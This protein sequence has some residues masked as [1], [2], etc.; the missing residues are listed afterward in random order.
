VTRVPLF[1]FDGWR[2]DWNPRVG[3]TFSRGL[4]RIRV[5]SNG[6]WRPGM[7]NVVHG[8]HLPARFMQV[9]RGALAFAR[10]STIGPPSMKGWG[11]VTDGGEQ[12]GQGIE[13]FPRY[14]RTTL[15]ALDGTMERHPVAA[16]HW[17]TG[18]PLTRT[19]LGIEE[20]VLDGASMNDGVPFQLRPFVGQDW[21]HKLAAWKRIDGAH[22][23]R[24]FSHAVAA[25]N[26]KRDPAA[27]LFLIAIGHEVMRSYATVRTGSDGNGWSLASQEFNVHTTPHTGGL[28]IVRWNAHC[29][30]AV[31]EM[32]KAAPSTLSEDWIRR[33]VDVLYMGQAENGA[34]ER[35][36]YASGLDQQEPVRLFGL[37]TRFEWCTSWQVPFMVV[38]VRQAMRA[39]PSCYA[40]G[41]TVLER[42][43]RLW[44]V[45]TVAGED[46]APHGLPRYLVV[47]ESGRLFDRV[48]W[49]VGPARPYYDADAFQSFAE[50]GL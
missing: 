47:A 9:D 3:H 36:D 48:T 18:E 45:P 17:D 38:A 30:R 43:K 23:V 41:R 10:V 8:P 4:E 39:V 19:Q 27:R 11:N 24:A 14:T 12:G 15:A 26:A 34:L 33:Y 29:L 37:D 46:N 42:A 49:G 7:S 44:D 16:F 21:G 40:H 20:Y 32:H 28:G 1:E 5:R 31:V 13:L 22:L 50:V 6:A 35:H 25:W 2:C